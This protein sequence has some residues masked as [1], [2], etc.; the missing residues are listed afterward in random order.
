MTELPDY[1]DICSTCIYGPI[2]TRRVY[3]KAPIWYCNEFDDHDPP[4]EL[5]RIDDHDPPPE[6]KRP[7]TSAAVARSRGPAKES[8]P[9]AAVAKGL[10]ANCENRD[11]CLMPHPEGGVWHCEE[12]R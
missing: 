6:N 8:A 3:A 7:G 1:N 2:C 12:Y 11:T 10:C 4:P 9:P 5:R